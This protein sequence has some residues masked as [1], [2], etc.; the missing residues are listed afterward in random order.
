VREGAKHEGGLASGRQR[1]RALARIVAL[2]GNRWTIEP[3]FRDT[4]DLRFGM[5]ISEGMGMSELRIDDPQRRDRLFLLNAFAILRLT[6]LGAAG[7]SLGMDRQLRTSTTRRRVHSLFRQGYL[8]YE[9]VP[10]LPED[11]LPPLIDKYTE[12]REKKT[13]SSHKLSTSSKMTGSVRRRTTF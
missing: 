12:L 6:V 7:E 3:S 5:G 9:V 2:Y 11:R 1:R 10:N 13:S 8:L 4:K